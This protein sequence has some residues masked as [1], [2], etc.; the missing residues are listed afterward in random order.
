MLDLKSNQ[1]E[2]LNLKGCPSAR[3]GHRMVFFSLSVTEYIAYNY[4]VLYA[5]PP[6]A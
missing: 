6:I 5:Y 4:Y 2:Q 1:W 3:S